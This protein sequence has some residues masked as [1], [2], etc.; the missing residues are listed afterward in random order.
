MRYIKQERDW[1]L[2]LISA[3]GLG[4]QEEIVAM[5]SLV[6]ECIT[7]IIVIFTCKRLLK[8]YLANN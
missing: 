8:G 4:S 6:R 5:D 2:I 3:G 1:D 7:K